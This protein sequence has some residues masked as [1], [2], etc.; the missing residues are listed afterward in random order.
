[1]QSCPGEIVPPG[2]VVS[3]SICTVFLTYSGT[4][5]YTIRQEATFARRSRETKV[6]FTGL[7]G[8]CVWAVQTYYVDLSC[9]VTRTKCCHEHI[10]FHKNSMFT[11]DLDKKVR[12]E[13]KL[14]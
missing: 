11:L 6:A 1:M 13:S 4:T 14:Y 8:C 3:T 12:K 5:F 10:M 2:E 7:D 9:C